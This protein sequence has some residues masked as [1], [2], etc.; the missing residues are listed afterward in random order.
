[1]STPTVTRSALEELAVREVHLNQLLAQTNDLDASLR[2]LLASVPQD[3][4]SALQGPIIDTVELDPIRDF[5]I[6]MKR[7]V[8]ARIGRFLTG[9]S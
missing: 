1:M 2:E 6:A 9:G 7:E 8:G 3:I 4:T 5:V